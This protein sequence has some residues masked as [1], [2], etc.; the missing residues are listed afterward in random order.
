[1]VPHLSGD[2]FAIF[3]LEPGFKLD[4]A[5]LEKAYRTVQSRVH[6]DKFA[7][8][9]QSERRLS[10]QAAARVNEA[11]R[12]LR[13]PLQRARYLLQLAGIDS[14]HESNTAMPAEFLLEQMEWREAV[15][16]AREA[17]DH[18]ALLSLRQRLRHQ[19][20]E[21]YGRVERQL[22]GE[23]NYQQAAEDVRRLM[24]VERIQHEIDEALDD[25]GDE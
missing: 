13:H 2:Y 25:V 1:M 10:M 15:A 12:T 8:L 14:A 23:K 24:F 18:D 6:P 4:G 3:G 19:S 7:H 22:D 11:Y 20:D 21:I 16:E 9:P 17:S 5:V